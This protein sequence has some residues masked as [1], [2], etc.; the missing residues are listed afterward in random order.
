[1]AARRIFSK[2]IDGQTHT[3]YATTPAAAVRLQFNGWR[4]LQAPVATTA[5]P[6]TPAPEGT[7]KPKTAPGPA[8]AKP[9][10]E[11]K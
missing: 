2:T 11:T 5:A 4:E 3:A 7:P 8:P 9:T 1:M 6:D 10:A